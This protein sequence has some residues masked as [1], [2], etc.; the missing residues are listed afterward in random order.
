M[1]LL[2]SQSIF[3]L[4]QTKL[5]CCWYLV[6]KLT[7]LYSNNFTIYKT[8]TV[9]LKNYLQPG[10]GTKKVEKHCSTAWVLTLGHK[11]KI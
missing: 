3:Y 11:F 8:G 2:I 6:E 5:A 10:L 9:N 1:N 7:E 4:I